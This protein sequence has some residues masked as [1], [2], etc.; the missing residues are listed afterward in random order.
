[1]EEKDTAELKVTQEGISYGSGDLPDPSYDKPTG[2]TETLSY[3]GTLR[4]DGSQY[5]PTIDKPTEAGSYKVS[6]RCET[7]ETIYSGSADF[8]IAPENIGGGTVTLG[9]ALTYNGSEQTQS[10]AAVMLD[11]ANILEDCTVS[12]NTGINAG[13]YTLTVTANENSNYTG[14]IQQVFNI[15]KA[16][17]TYDDV[18]STVSYAAASKTVALTCV[19]SDAG[20]IEIIEM[21]GCD[22][23][24]TKEFH[25]L[26]QILQPVSGCWYP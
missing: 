4:R 10:A 7:E 1:M 15:A 24:F 9:D 6:V 17:V 23:C 8:T 11:G 26:R 16:R 22:A 21:K 18:E 5:G 19:P 20:K 13:S 2:G 12:N 14:T 3:T 25:Q